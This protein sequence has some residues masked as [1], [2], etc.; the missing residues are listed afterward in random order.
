MGS[1]DL[2]SLAIN[3]G[4]TLGVALALIAATFLLARVRGRY[5]TIDSL[6]GL[7]FAVIALVGLGLSTGHG[8]LAGRLLVTALTVVWG[9][10]LSIHIHTRNAHQGEDARYAAMVRKA[11]DAP[12]R[13]MLTRVYLVQA[14]LMWLISLP[15]QAAQY[16]RGGLGVLGWI[17]VAVWLVGIGFEG[18]GDAQLRRFKADPSNKGTVLDQ[19]LWRYTRHPNYFGDACVWWGLYLLACHSWAGVATVF[20]PLVMTALLARGS[21]KPILERAM[22]ARRP[23][24]ADYVRRTSGFFPLPPKRSTSARGTG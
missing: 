24:Y 17:G 1:S 23:A 8:E 14:V 22:L 7:G 16:A 9:L 4:I 11:G 3:A 12:G 20:A 6:W 21:G 5:D 15:V 2:G 18:I 10:R 19:G 13:Y